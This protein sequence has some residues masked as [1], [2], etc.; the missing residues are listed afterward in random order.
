M[1]SL[2]D[3]NGCRMDASMPTQTSAANGPSRPF[4]GYDRE[5][6]TYDRLKLELL[7]RAAGQFVGIVGDELVGPLESLQEVERA[8]HAK[9]GPRALYV[10]QILS[11]NPSSVAVHLPTL[12]HAGIAAQ[13]LQ[14]E[15]LAP[16]ETPRGQ[17]PFARYDRER[18]A[19][20]QT[21]PG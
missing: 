1:S 13:S 5:R 7:A 19:L 10:R 6:A 9:F 18:A 11:E 16:A 4:I 14:A 20:R 17:R 21:G 8:G 3:W 12:L 2:D 15:A